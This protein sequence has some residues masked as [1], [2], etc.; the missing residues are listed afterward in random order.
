LAPGQ[1]RHHQNNTLRIQKPHAFTASSSGKRSFINLFI[2]W[3]AI[4]F[5]PSILLSFQYL[6]CALKTQIP[7]ISLMK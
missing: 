3:P 4:I 2:L 5:I 1:G 7:L 6:T